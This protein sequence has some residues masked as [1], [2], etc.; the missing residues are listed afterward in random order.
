MLFK[1]P[2]YYKQALTCH[3]KLSNLTDKDSPA[4]Q[5]LSHMVRSNE[6]VSLICFDVFLKDVYP[7]YK[8]EAV[9]QRKKA[10]APQ[11]VKYQEITKVPFDIESK[12][13]HLDYPNPDSGYDYQLYWGDR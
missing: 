13:Y 12:S 2:L 3:Y 5:Y 1:A 8:K 4:E 11:G 7:D 6:T 9:F 10:S